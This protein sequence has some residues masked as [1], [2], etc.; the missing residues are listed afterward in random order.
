MVL[1]LSH[2]HIN[3]TSKFL[4][5]LSH[6][7]CTTILRD[8]GNKKVGWYSINLPFIISTRTLPCCFF[9]LLLTVVQPRS[10]ESPTTLRLM[11]LHHNIIST[12]SL[13]CCFYFPS[14]LSPTR[15]SQSLLTL[16]L[17]SLPDNNISTLSL[18]CHFFK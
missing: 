1:V 6:I 4:K 15:S 5:D 18:P 13:P 9:L 3:H 2:I 16:W 12:Q 8:V 17:F 11:S 7:R 14:N 10:S